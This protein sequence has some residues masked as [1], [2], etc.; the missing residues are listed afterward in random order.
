[1]PTSVHVMRI[2]R[3]GE[4]EAQCRYLSPTPDST[5][6]F[7][8]AK[9]TKSTKSRVDDLVANGSTTIVGRADNCDGQE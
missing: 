4:G 9:V 3:Y 8:C 7:T 6:Q 1:M 2:C 5:G